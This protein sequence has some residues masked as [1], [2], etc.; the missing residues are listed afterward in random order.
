MAAPEVLPAGGGGVRFTKERARAH[1][2]RD[3]TRED[4]GGASDC[5]FDQGVSAARHLPGSGMRYSETIMAAQSKVKGVIYEA[6]TDRVW[7]ILVSLKHRRLQL[8][9]DAKIVKIRAVLASFR[10]SF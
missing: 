6:D 2:G 5:G 1:S 3:G 9:N 4:R 10:A 8:L 7:T